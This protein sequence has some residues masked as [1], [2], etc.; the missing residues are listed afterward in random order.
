MKSIISFV[1]V[2]MLLIPAVVSVYGQSEFKQ[3]KGNFVEFQYPVEWESGMTEGLETKGVFTEG[4]HIP[5]DN[6]ISLIFQ[7]QKEDLLFL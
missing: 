7:I 5:K 1:L 6:R 3:Y 2:I 4:S